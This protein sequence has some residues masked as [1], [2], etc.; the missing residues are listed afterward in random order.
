MRTK[1]I[2]LITFWLSFNSLSLLAADV[3]ELPE[4]LKRGLVLHFDFDTEPAGGKI[5]DVSG[6]NNNGQL[7]GATWV[8]EGH[9]GGA[10]R[11]TPPNEYIH[12]PNSS[13]L[14]PPQVTLSVWIKTS[15]HDNTFRRVVDKDYKTGYSLTIG[16]A[17]PPYSRGRAYFEINCQSEWAHRA[18]ASDEPVNDGRW[19]HLVGTFDTSG[20]R[21]YVD[22]HLQKR[23]LRDRRDLLPN[24]SDLTIGMNPVNPTPGEVGASFDGLVDDVMIFNRGLSTEEVQMLYNLQKVATDEAMPSKT[25]PA[26]PPPAKPDAATRLKQVKQLYD[27]GLINKDEYDRKVKE[28][29]DSL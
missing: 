6:A 26:N 28:I 16:G 23:I 14:N 1:L 13:S 21:L 22:G 20:Q 5:A 11:F 2:T 15:R 29:M 7:V 12:V 18:I 10:C 17:P 27:Q 24:D 25:P 3:H 19:H 4:N 9:Q 8:A